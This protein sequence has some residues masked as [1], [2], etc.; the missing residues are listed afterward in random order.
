LGD[1]GLPIFY[2]AAAIWGNH[3]GSIYLFLVII[4]LYGSIITKKLN[5]RTKI[6]FKHHPINNNRSETN[7][8]TNL[9]PH[10][11]SQLR[12]IKPPLHQPIGLKPLLCYFILF[13][14]MTS[15][16][17]LPIYSLFRFGGPGLNP[18]L[19]DVGLIIH[20]PILYLGYVGAIFIYLLYLSVDSEH[21]KNILRTRGIILVPHPQHQSNSSRQWIILPSPLSSLFKL[22]GD[23]IAIPWIFLTIGILLGS[24]WAYYE[25]GW[26]G[27]WFWD[28]VE[29]L[30][31]LPW[32]FITLIYHNKVLYR[33]KNRF[34]LGTLFPYL[35]FISALFGTFL[36]RIG[37]FNSVHS[38][39]S[40]EV[41]ITGLIF[42][43]LILVHLSPFHYRLLL[44][45]RDN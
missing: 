44:L 14:L 3:E 31:L 32:L 8:S 2:R 30:A 18:I 4:M 11:L 38:F 24:W 22:L 29:N 7:G 34:L 25:L 35:T 26:G 27:W 9:S 16:P 28:P 15:N 13:I 1:P 20:P 39:A 23:F 37:V 45:K 33:P 12:N 36:I 40:L 5:Q 21:M 6:R 17:F 42:L 19:Q 43:V 10:L 41:V